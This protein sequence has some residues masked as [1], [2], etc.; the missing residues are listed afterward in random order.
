MIAPSQAEN[1]D[2]Y[3]MPCT[4]AQNQTGTMREENRKIDETSKITEIFAILFIPAF[5]NRYG[6]NVR[7]KKI[8]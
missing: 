1:T 5:W 3:E 2:P 4:P 7:Y 8:R 6:V